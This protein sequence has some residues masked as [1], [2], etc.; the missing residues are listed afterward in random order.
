MSVF[1]SVFKQKNKMH[2]SEI[3]ESS[4]NTFNYTI[5]T[6][7]WTRLTE[8]ILRTSRVNVGNTFEMS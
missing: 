2:N 1:T 7:G 4:Q 8:R 3:S 6:Q 5:S